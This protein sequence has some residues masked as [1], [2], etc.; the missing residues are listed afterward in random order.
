MKLKLLVKQ[1]TPEGGATQFLEIEGNH[2]LIGRKDC[3]VVLSDPNCSRNHALLYLSRAGEL[4]VRDLQSTNGTYLNQHRVGESTLR[5]GDEIRIGGATLLLV[6]FKNEVSS[7]PP[8]DPAQR[9]REVT[10]VWTKEDTKTLQQA[11]EKWPSVE[12]L[13]ER[14]GPAHSQAA[15]P[16]VSKL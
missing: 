16:R 15:R 1:A 7:P 11:A 6:D 9:A 2:C 14:G 4:Q 10:V 3:D 12:T 8:V 5:V 13:I